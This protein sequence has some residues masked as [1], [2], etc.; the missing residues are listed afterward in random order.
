MRR[1][2]VDPERWRRWSTHRPTAPDARRS[3]I[4]DVSP[5]VGALH[6]GHGVVV[7]RALAVPVMRRSALRLAK[8]Y[9][10]PRD[11]LRKRGDAPPV[12]RDALRKRGDAR[13]RLRPRIPTVLAVTSLFGEVHSKMGSSLHCFIQFASPRSVPL[14]RAQ[15]AAPTDLCRVGEGR[16]GRAKGVRS[17]SGREFTK[18]ILCPERHRDAPGGPIW[19]LPEGADSGSE[20]D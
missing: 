10:Y 20:F 6:E 8:P 15:H 9:Q 16:T 4:R 3:R 1:C 14:L 13:F 12:P 5:A 19:S 11:A 7:Y 17:G 2:L 18:W